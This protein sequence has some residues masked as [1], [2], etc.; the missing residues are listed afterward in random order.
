MRVTVKKML[1]TIERK[2]RKKIVRERLKKR[3]KEL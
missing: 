1:N 3:R 2:E